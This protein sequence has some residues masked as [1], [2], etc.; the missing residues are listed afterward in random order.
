MKKLL[1]IILVAFSM[2][3]SAQKTTA[4]Q[5]ILDRINY[6][7]TAWNEGNIEK[8]MEPYWRS[9]SLVFLGKNGATYGW[10][11]TYDNYKKGYPDKA[12]M[13]TLKFTII[14]VKK[15]S[16]N[17]YNVIGK[18][19]LERDKGNVGGHFTLLWQKINGQ[20]FIIQ[21]HTS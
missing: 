17:V 12:T 3:G 1:T 14:Q 15:L 8:F 10:Q 18:W 19:E 7:Q 6:Q 13:G 21:D 4:K 9:D 11:N 5:M 2:H 16:G 20:W